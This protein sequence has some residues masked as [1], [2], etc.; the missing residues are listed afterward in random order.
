MTS[1]STRR[2]SAAKRSTTCIGIRSSGGWWQTRSTGM[3]QLPPLRDRRPRYR[4]IESEW[5][6]ARR[7]RAT[8]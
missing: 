4:G 7:N 6:A 5:T 1:T 3:V 8:A 2:A